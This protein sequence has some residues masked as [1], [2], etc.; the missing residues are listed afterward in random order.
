MLLVR[1]IIFILALF[2]VLVIADSSYAADEKVKK[3]DISEVDFTTEE[4]GD[5]EFAFLD[6]VEDGELDDN[7]GSFNENLADLEAIVNNNAA[8]NVHTG[9]NIL[10][11][12]AFGNSRGFV[13]VIQNSGANVVI[14]NS[15]I[16]NVTMDSQ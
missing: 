7:R 11:D 6:A 4:L 3:D 16:L 8:V 10:T 14:Q 9:D 5:D 2:T 12:N 1:N 13:N 15:T